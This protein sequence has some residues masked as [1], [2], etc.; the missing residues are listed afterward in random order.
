[1][2]STN[3]G[4]QQRKHHRIEGGVEVAAFERGFQILPSADRVVQVPQPEAPDGVKAC[5][6]QL[7]GERGT[8][9][10]SCMSR[11]IE[12]YTNVGRF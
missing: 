11:R 4:A 5:S 2:V 1:M 3:S 6:I 10:S 12:I 7:S 8:P 9:S